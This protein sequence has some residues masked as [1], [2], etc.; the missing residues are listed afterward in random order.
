M[1]RCGSCFLYVLCCRPFLH[2]LF[3]KTS[4]YD[5]QL[6]DKQK[7]EKDV[8]VKDAFAVDFKEAENDQTTVIYLCHLKN[9]TI[10]ELKCGILCAIS[11][12]LKNSNAN[13]T[14]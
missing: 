9:Y 2:F 12:Y 8:K 4:K 11:I 10:S 6:K 5:H 13:P 1:A 3:F 7:H 14:Q